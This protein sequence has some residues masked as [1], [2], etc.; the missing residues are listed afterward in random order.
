MNKPYKVRIDKDNL[1]TDNPSPTGA[2]L[3][4][5]AGKTPVER[6]QIFQ[7]KGND[8]E[9]VKLTDHV[10]LTKPGVEHFVTLPLD[11]TEGESQGPH[12]DFALSEEDT[13]I[14]DGLGFR[15]ETIAEKSV[16]R[17]V[18]RKYRL[19][20]GYNHAT[21]DISLRIEPSYPTTQIDM[22][23]VSPP[24]ARA[25]GGSIG[26]LSEFQFEDRT[27]QQWSRHRTGENPWRAGIDNIGTHLK[28]V[29]HWFARELLKPKH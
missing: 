14:L 17:V 13:E 8:L 25:D 5:L 20:A 27:W 4:A 18:L 9:E 1:E 23:S 12:R 16:A 15:W 10:D 6:F 2:E 26:G 29:D 19:P 3:L 21:A 11:Q 22:V 7:R 28:L 24:L